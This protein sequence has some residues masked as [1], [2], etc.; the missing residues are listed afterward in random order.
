MHDL[1][2]T[3]GRI[4]TSEAIR[5]ADIAIADGRIAS[6]HAPGLAVEARRRIDVS[7][8]LLF[9]GLVDA[10]VHLREP[11]L[12]H[13]EDFETGTRAAAAGGVTTLLVMPTDDPWTDTPEHLKAKIALAQ[14]RIHADVAFQVVVGRED[15]DLHVLRDLGAVSFEVFTADVPE[16]Y[17]H[18]SIAAL[19]TALRRLRDT[20]VRI[21]VSPGEQS[22]LEATAD[23][24]GI[25]EFLAS[26]PPLGEAM[27]IAR[28]ILAASDTGTAIHIRQINSALGVETLR[29]L[30]SL[31]DVSAETTPQNLL[32]TTPDYSRL[33]N[34]IKASPPFRAA[35]D[36][37]VL[38]EALRD[39][40][41][42]IVATDHA[43][44]A[45]DEKA[46][47]YGRFSD[48][49]GGMAGVQTLLPVML[50]L[51]AKGVIGL[52]DI[53]RLCALNP[54]VRFGLGGR[55]GAIAAGHDADI[56]VV[57]PAGS[58]VIA[59]EG[60]HSKAQVTPFAGLSFPYVIEAS[61]LRGETVYQA[62]TVVAER[63]GQVLRPAAV[64]ESGD[65][66]G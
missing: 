10:H 8:R 63:R 61:F 35:G 57:N 51:A 33:G 39:G 29:R 2:L 3:G 15:T 28:A 19:A 54:A 41:V 4:V 31:A 45:P 58:T 12:T 20:G 26:R 11:G 44:H 36:V 65:S 60:Q 32:F 59:N 25:A 5:E 50:H 64:V 21:A 6:L 66:D 22:I 23:N 18:D 38:G 24:G 13:K 7:G 52:T 46:K 47:A 53:A 42:D 34:I 14:G 37:A 55:K 1:L 27:G 56:V 62:G 9:P 43:P 40:T 49:P 48:V 16:R 30:K 17:R